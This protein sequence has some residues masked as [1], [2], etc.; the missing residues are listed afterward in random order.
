VWDYHVICALRCPGAES[1]TL[2]YDLDSSLPFGCPLEK[3]VDE[4]FKP[5]EDI[6]KRFRQVFRVVE[7]EEFMMTFSSDRSHMLTAP[8]GG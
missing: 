1:R 4:A 6:R 3:Y 2:I 5:S 7:G 8:G